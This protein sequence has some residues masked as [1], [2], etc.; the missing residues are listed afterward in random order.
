MC[1]CM[2]RGRA[3]SCG[4]NAGGI[5]SATGACCVIECQWYAEC[6]AKGVLCL[7]F[8]QWF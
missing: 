4:S 2:R 6:Y 3:P 7:L 5:A 1:S 8:G